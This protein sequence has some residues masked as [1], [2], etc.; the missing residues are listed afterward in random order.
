MRAQHPN[1]PQDRD[2]LFLIAWKRVRIGESVTGR[3]R[4]AEQLLQ[5]GVGE[6]NQ[7]EVEGIRFE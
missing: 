1:V 3:L 7:V 2:N 5:L 4:V 6:A